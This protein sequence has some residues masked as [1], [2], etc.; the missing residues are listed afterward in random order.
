MRPSHDI[1]P[2]VQD[3]DDWSV[4]SES[5]IVDDM[6]FNDLGLSPITYRRR[7]DRMS[8]H[9][10]L[11]LYRQGEADGLFGGAAFRTR[12]GEI[13]LFDQGP[14][15][16]G[17]TGE[18]HQMASA[19]VPYAAI[20]YDPSRHSGHIRVGPETAAGRMLWSSME[21]L[22]A[23]LPRAAAPE[24]SAMTT[25]FAGLIE[26]L[27]LSGEPSAACSR[28]FDATRRLAMRRYLDDHLTDS[29]L[30]AASLATAFGASRA[31][32]YRDFAEE[33][34]VARFVT[35][36]R[37]E[38]AFHDLATIPPDRGRV[39]RVA[40]RWG[41]ACPYHFS[42]AFRRQFGIWPSEV[43]EASRAGE[44]APPFLRPCNPAAP[45][46]STARD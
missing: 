17:A 13:H 38:R 15:C 41:F 1:L 10:L 11:R 3:S 4:A 19:F 34:G 8:Q 5:W 24:A 9:V 2:N 33:G 26:G 27:L 7:A 37:L 36:R 39:R 20:G 42:R 28:D 12:P 23:E 18:W 21:S 45:G 14:E 6:I 16:S 29:G 43:F 35:R 32:I 25:G 22:F 30:G 40:E 44:D 46:G 31:T